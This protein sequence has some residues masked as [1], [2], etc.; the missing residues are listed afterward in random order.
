[1]GSGILV[2]IPTCNRPTLCRRA[3]D[4]LLAQEE[5]DWSL[6]IAKNGGGVN[7]DRYFRTLKGRLN[8][9][10]CGCWCF[11]TPVWATR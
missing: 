5:C 4:S 3:V 1:M 6:V 9:S 7:L 10:A 8:H 2:V 11:P